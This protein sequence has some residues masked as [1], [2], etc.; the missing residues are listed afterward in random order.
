MKN[1]EKGKGRSENQ[2]LKLFYLLDYLL[3]DFFLPATS[4]LLGFFASL[5]RCEVSRGIPSPALENLFAIGI[6]PQASLELKGHNFLSLC[7]FLNVSH[8]D[9]LSTA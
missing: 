6:P 9:R 8:F 7:L 4:H 5:G 3:L 1:G 2:R